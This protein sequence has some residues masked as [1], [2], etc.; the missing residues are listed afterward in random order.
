MDLQDIFKGTNV[1]PFS[2]Q[3]EVKVWHKI[4]KLAEDQLDKY[5]TSYQEDLELLDKDEKESGLT[6]N[7]R[8][9][10]LFRS[11][12]KKILHFL[13]TTAERMIALS[14]MSQKDAKKHVNQLKDFDVC[15]DYFKS[16]ILPVLPQQ[17]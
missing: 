9:C 3:A 8:N 14:E 12:E 13:V 6:Y 5:P 16:V 1:R 11:G 7:K 4:K 15:M 10:V 17:K 2:L